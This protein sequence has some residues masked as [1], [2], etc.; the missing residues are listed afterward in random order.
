MTRNEQAKRTK[1]MISRP[2]R[3]ELARVVKIR[4]K[5]AK[6]VVEQRKA[7]LLA[8]VEAQLEQH[9]VRVHA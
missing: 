3:E 2:D 7:E 4:L 5:A 8:D 6:S 9:A 1:A